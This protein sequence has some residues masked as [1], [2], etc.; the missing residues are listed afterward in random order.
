MLCRSDDAAPLLRAYSEKP[1][2]SLE[3]RSAGYTRREPIL[4]QCP[5][6]DR[7]AFRCQLIDSP[8]LP[9]GVVNQ[10]V[11][12]DTPGQ[13]GHDPG[14]R[15]PG[16]PLAGVEMDVE[17]TVRGHCPE[18]LGLGNRHGPSGAWMRTS[19]MRIGPPSLPV[20]SCRLTQLSGLI[21]SSQRADA[22]QPS[23]PA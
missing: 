22:C 1:R 21:A 11:A 5:Y 4:R 8:R 12:T 19:L 9:V 15:L 14:G 18:W 7:L 2:Y 20:I 13:H 10:R 23:R 3:V 16:A 17:A 6:G